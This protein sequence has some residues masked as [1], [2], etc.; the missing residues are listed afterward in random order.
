MDYNNSELT[1]IDTKK[2]V[3]YPSNHIYAGLINPKATMSSGSLQLVCSVVSN[4]HNPTAWS[5]GYKAN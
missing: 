3:Y 1:V 2:N 5:N 4:G